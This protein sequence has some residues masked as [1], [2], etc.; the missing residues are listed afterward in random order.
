MA[1]VS[2]SM[3]VVDWGQVVLLSILWGGSFFFIGVAIDDL[4]HLTIVFSRV[5]LAAAALIVAVLLAGLTMPLKLDWWRPLMVMSIL[6]NVIPWTMITWGQTEIA[7]G[8]AAIFNATT[9]LFTVV[10]ANFFTA[11][12]KLTPGKIFG[13]V[14]GFCGV[15][16]MIGPD[17]LE[18]LGTALLAQLAVIAACVSY[19]CSGVFARRLHDRPPL[20]LAAGQMVCSTLFM[21]PLMLV[22]ASPWSQ[23][24]PEWP[25]IAAIICLGL[26]S[27]AFAYFLVFRIIRSAG[28]TNFSLVTFLLPITA[29]ILGAAFL[30]E[31]LAPEA[32]IGMA[33]IGLGLAAI[34]GRPAAALARVAGKAG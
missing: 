24:I 14:L 6:N 28:A 34:D 1:A 30:G 33:L 13:V 20:T 8:L 29:I 3:S 32:F 5:A 25:T 31:R 7:S 2:R 16:V 17:L 15:S 19:A 11:D 27:T 4:H 26:F 10:I 18:G 9:P 22:F 23:P 21:L 12:E